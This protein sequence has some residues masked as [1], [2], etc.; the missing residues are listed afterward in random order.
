MSPGVKLWHFP[1]HVK[2]TWGPWRGGGT[3]QMSS[4]WL[5]RCCRPEW[6]ERSGTLAVEDGRTDWDTPETKQNTDSFTSTR[7][8]TSQ[9][10][11]KV[12]QVWQDGVFRWVTTGVHVTFSGVMMVMPLVSLEVTAADRDRSLVVSHITH[13]SSL[14]YTF[15]ELCVCLD[16]EQLIP[17]H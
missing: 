6:A 16:T 15:T 3:M 7:T 12:S 8:T 13:Y 17:I 9:H 5:N 2:G 10:G 1:Q 11:F 14:N 4:R